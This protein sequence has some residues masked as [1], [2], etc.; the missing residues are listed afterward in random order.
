MAASADVTPPAPKREATPVDPLERAHAN[1]A[2]I[3]A[4]LVHHFPD[5][6]WDAPEELTFTA[7]AIEQVAR[8]ARMWTAQRIGRARYEAAR[9]KGAAVPPKHAQ[10]WPPPPAVI[11]HARKKQRT[12]RETFAERRFREGLETLLARN[13]QHSPLCV[14]R[15][16]LAPQGPL[17]TRWGLALRNFAPNV[18]A[19]VAQRGGRVTTARTGAFAKVCRD[20]LAVILLHEKLPSIPTLSD[21]LKKV[22]LI[23]TDNS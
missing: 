3:H 22:N 9:R 4:I 23:G 18:A 2:L 21:E 8:W 15:P 20:L 11:E 17:P 5:A 12:G 13:E 10:I 19:A 16:W 1:A 6:R 7:L 14:A